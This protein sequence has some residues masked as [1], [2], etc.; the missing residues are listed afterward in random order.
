MRFKFSWLLLIAALA[1]LTFMPAVAQDSVG[2]ATI[3]NLDEYVA[4]TGTEITEFHEAPSLAEKVAAGELPPVEERLPENPIVIVPWN[5]VGQ[6]GGTLRWDEFTVDYDHYF[7]HILNTQ[8]ALR[9]ASVTTY[10]NSGPGSPD[11][12]RPFVFEGWEQNDDATEFTIH[13]R[14]GLKWSD[15]VELTTED[16]RF[17]LEDE[18]FSEELNPGLTSRPYIWGGEPMQLD[19]IDDYTFKLTFAAPY[20][21]FVE[22]NL[23]DLS[24]GSISRFLTPAHFY[25]QYHTA[26]T[27]ISEILPVMEENGFTEESEWANFYRSAWAGDFGDSGPY[28]DHTFNLTL[29]VLYPWVMSEIR[30]DGTE[31]LTR[32]PYYFVV[33]TAGNQLPYIDQLQRQFIND[34]ELMNLDIIAGKVDVQGQFIKI[35]DFP[36]FKQNEEAG[37]YNALPVR[38]WQHHTLIYWFNPEV[39]D[40]KLSAALSEI[41]FRRALSIALDRNQIN[42]VVYR[43]LGT[44]AQFAPPMDT[45]LY[46]ESLSSFAAEYDPEGAMALLE[47]LGYV[48]VNG[49]GFRE[50]PD[51][52]EFTLPITYY[53]VTP[54]ANQGA[55]LATDYW[56]AV[57]IQVNTRQVDGSQFWNLQGANEVAAGIWWANGPDFGDGSFIGQSVNVPTWNTWINT[58]GEDG[59]EPPDWVK[60]IRE[61]QDQRLEVSAEERAALDSEGWNLLVNNLTIIGTVENGKNPLILNKG[62]GNVEY[63]FDKNFVAPTYWEWAFQW[64]Y[65]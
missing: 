54:A 59:I 11:P 19:V 14:K 25:K 29:P 53:E 2:P 44:P 49:D 9:D 62:L 12:A 47:G 41:D 17:R 46:D 37:N 26:Y 20:G 3:H 39:A 24:W 65:K 7:R 56:Q 15:G 45:P 16:V 30:P 1:L 61:I 52:S 42:E 57:G 4:A 55:V 5:E 64:Y 21:A 32:N 27:D 40:E 36:L 63:G 35:D 13:L 58:N 6:Y 43:G 33:D 18:I 50:A 31:I 8:T 28:V 22:D 38:A 34:S 10:Y 48:D 23:R 60:R 51:G